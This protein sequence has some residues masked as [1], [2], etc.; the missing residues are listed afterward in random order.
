MSHAPGSPRSWVA[1]KRK[2]GEVCKLV[3]KVPGIRC[4]FQKRQQPGHSVKAV[5]GVGAEGRDR[6]FFSV[7]TWPLVAGGASRTLQEV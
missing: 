7:S 2:G 3:G 6:M 4:S 5:T 1:V